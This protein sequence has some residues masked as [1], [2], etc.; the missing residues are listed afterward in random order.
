M[1][2]H[3][4][5]P[6]HDDVTIGSS[7]RKP[8]PEWGNSRHIPHVAPPTMVDA[9]EPGAR[10]QCYNHLYLPSSAQMKQFIGC[11]DEFQLG[12]TPLSR[13]GKIS[14]FRGNCLARCFAER[15]SHLLG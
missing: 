6:T 11:L 8:W 5:Q 3:L 14:Y 12:K 2:Q 1:K 4:A 9:P 13:Y 10:A 7:S 15:S